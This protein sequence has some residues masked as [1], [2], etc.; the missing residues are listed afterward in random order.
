MYAYTFA[1]LSIH[2]CSP[3][4]LDSFLW[5]LPG[6][7]QA[8]WHVLIGNCCMKPYNI[9]GAAMPIY[10]ILAQVTDIGT[11]HA[12]YGTGQSSRGTLMAKSSY[13]ARPIVAIYLAICLFMDW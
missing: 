13:L 10:A 4:K 6:S 2:T 11:V 8:K 12:E 7:G 9:K 5:E 3:G 1:W